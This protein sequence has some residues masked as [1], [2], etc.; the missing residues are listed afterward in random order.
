MDITEEEL[1]ALEEQY[2]SAVNIADKPKEEIK[3]VEDLE[4]F[5]VYNEETKKEETTFL[6]YKQAEENYIWCDNLNCLVLKENTAKVY[7]LYYSLLD[8]DD[9]SEYITDVG[10][11]LNSFTDDFLDHTEIIH[12]NNISNYHYIKEL[13]FYYII[14]DYEEH[15]LIYN[16]IDRLIYIN[17]Y[18]LLNNNFE[19]NDK[20]EIIKIEIKNLDFSNI[21]NYEVFKSCLDDFHKDR[22]DIIPIFTSNYKKELNLV[23][24]YP[25]IN[26]TNSR[27]FK[28]VIKELYVIVPLHVENKNFVFSGNLYGFR[29]FQT[30]DERDSNY[31]HSHSNNSKILEIGKFCLGSGDINLI[32]RNL[33]TRTNFSDVL[34]KGFLLTLDY[35][36]TWESLEGGPHRKLEVLFNKSQEINSSGSYTLP[37]INNKLF[38]EIF[39]KITPIYSNGLIDYNLKDIENCL[40]EFI[41]H[42]NYN[43]DYNYIVNYDP[44]TNKYYKITSSNINK[45]IIEDSNIIFKGN[46]IKGIIKASVSVNNKNI[47]RVVNPQCTN[48]VRTE[49]IK[50][51]GSSFFESKRDEEIRKTYSIH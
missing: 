9:L 30:S 36:L 49:F 6:S 13:N 21:E 3:S 22:W 14:S 7:V 44:D 5:T 46:K 20:N 4:E 15:K 8:N 10:W 16:P 27:D 19:R 31:I 1:R 41:T 32:I 38:I 40:S 29:T 18:H 2:K 12:K 17:E 50:R 25:E 37:I 45:D 23:I 43:T 26:I 34:L 47:K 48:Y 11:N 33:M 39:S 42:M 28:H 51:L 24:F 35:Y